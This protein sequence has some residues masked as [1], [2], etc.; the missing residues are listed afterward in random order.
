MPPGGGEEA[1][2]RGQIEAMSTRETKTD[3]DRLHAIMRLLAGSVNTGLYATLSPDDCRYLLLILSR[4]VVR[5]GGAFDATMRKLST[6][7]SELA[8]DAIDAL[9]EEVK[10][11]Y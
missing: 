2:C 3:R 1:S 10:K 6:K 8:Q 4:D 9:G 7:L 11:G 5:R